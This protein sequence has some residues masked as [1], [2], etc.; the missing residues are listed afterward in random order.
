MGDE[1][2]EAKIQW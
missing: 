2:K 1:R